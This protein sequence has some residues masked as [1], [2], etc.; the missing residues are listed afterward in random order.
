MPDLEM[1]SDPFGGSGRGPYAD[2]FPELPECPW[3]PGDAIPACDFDKYC[4]VHGLCVGCGEPS[5]IGSHGPSQE[6]GGCV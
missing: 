3:I 1:N 5:H 6:Y 4:P 2:D